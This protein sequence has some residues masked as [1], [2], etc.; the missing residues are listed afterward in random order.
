MTGDLDASEGPELHVYAALDKQPWLLSSELA[1]TT[2]RPY[3]RAA[4]LMPS[5][6]CMLPK[7]S[8]R[9]A[10]AHM[11]IVGGYFGELTAE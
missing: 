11:L 5:G 4:P 10:V 2:A 9:L 6:V 1:C 7:V 3:M 8:I